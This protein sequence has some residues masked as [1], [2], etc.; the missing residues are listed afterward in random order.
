[1][2]SRGGGLAKPAKRANISDATTLLR[3]AAVVRNGSHIGNGNDADT[4]CT[5][6]TNRRLTAWARSFDLDIQILDALIN[7][8]TTS[9]FRGN[10]CC[11]RC[12]LAR[13]LETLTTG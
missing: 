12:G 10:L 5:Q 8:S 2:E 11:E 3:A 13:T 9:N 4:Q 7:G 6:S 1:M